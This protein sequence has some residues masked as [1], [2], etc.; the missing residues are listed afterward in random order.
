M[1]FFVGLHSTVFVHAGI[2]RFAFCLGQ[3][4]I[5]IAESNVNCQPFLYIS[6][7]KRIKLFIIISIE[8]GI[9]EIHSQFKRNEAHATV[10]K[11]DKMHF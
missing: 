10:R 7:S 8:L 5:S 3:T 9:K 4:S 6:F 1:K 11:C 2:L